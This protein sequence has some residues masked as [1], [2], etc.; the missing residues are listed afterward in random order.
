MLLYLERLVVSFHHHAETYVETFVL[1]C[2]IRV[3]SVLHETACIFLIQVYV[4]ALF[5]EVLVQF[6]QFIELTGQVHHRAEFTFLIDELQRWN[7]G[8]FRYL[9]IVGT[10]CRSDMYDTCTVFRSHIVT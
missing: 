7:T 1:I 3:V 4:Y 8:G 2:Q 9:G 10:E 5:H 6:V